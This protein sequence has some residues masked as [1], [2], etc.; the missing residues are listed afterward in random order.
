MTTM[1]IETLEKAKEVTETLGD[2][3]S[4]AEAVADGEQDT[5]TDQQ[6]EDLTQA[7]AF[8]LQW[9]HKKQAELTEDQ[10]DASDD[11]EL[12][13]ETLLCIDR[14]SGEA[15]PMVAEHLYDRLSKIY[16]AM[17]MHTTMLHAQEDK[18]LDKQHDRTYY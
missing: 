3:R 16:T 2:A 17:V 10:F 18:K 1:D 11:V 12:L 5:P 6:M 9:V 8:I 14:F 13:V 7:R 15:N 4:H